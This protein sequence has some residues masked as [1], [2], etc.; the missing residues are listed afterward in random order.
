MSTENNSTKWLVGCLIA[1]VVGV[2]LCGGTVA[3]IGF[4]G[5]KAA[6]QIAQDMGPQL[7]QQIEQLKELGE[8][9]QF[10]DQ[11]Q[12][13]APGAGPEELLPEAVGA[14]TRISHDD[15]T[16]I[17]ELAIARDGF[18]GA[19]EFDATTI[20][21]YAYPL[22]LKEQGQLF[23]EAANAIE[24]AGYATRSQA[25][26]DMGSFHWMTFSFDP[27]QRFGRMWWAKDWLFVTMT[28]EP[29]VDL[30]SFEHDY[31]LANQGPWVPGMDETSPDLAPTEIAP[32]EAVTDPRS[33]EPV[34]PDSAPDNPDAAPADP[35]TTDSA[36][37]DPDSAAANPDRGN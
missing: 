9:M 22:P 5:Y 21:V 18:H 27:P 19:Y 29:G 24:M 35:G 20:E 28:G 10:A 14:W 7:Q 34:D 31:L 2:L 17:P 8:Q 26:E 25:N 32:P 3:L 30:E 1:G 33:V 13:P 37:D 15:L 16:A 6:E 36:P 23:G 11:W 12:P 4:W